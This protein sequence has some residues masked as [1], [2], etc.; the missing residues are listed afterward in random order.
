ME[1]QK[2]YTTMEQSE[3]L[4]AMG[5]PADS[6]DMYYSRMK[7]EQFEVPKVL[8]E[9]YSQCSNFHPHVFTYLPC[10]STGRLIEIFNIVTPKQER[11]LFWMN[12]TK[13]KIL[14]YTGV[15][16]EALQ[17]LKDHDALDLSKLEL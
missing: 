5:L 8:W 9:T 6:A 2:H 16:V 17:E 1:L 14:N 7:H 11:F 3:Q 15:F 10:W 12:I 13:Y 4:L